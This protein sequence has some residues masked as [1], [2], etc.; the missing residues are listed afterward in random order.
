VGIREL[1]ATRA[2]DKAQLASLTAINV[3]ATEA[4]NALKAELEQLRATAQS[5]EL[6]QV[7]QLISRLTT[8]I[9]SGSLENIRAAELVMEN[10]HLMV[11]LH[12]AQKEVEE[13]LHGVADTP[14][15]AGDAQTPEDFDADEPELEPIEPIV[16]VE[17]VDAVTVDMRQEID[18]ENWYGAEADGRWAGPG[19][20]SSITMPPVVPGPYV[21]EIYLADAMA[22]DIVYGLRLEAFG[23]D[24][25]FEL[26]AAVTREAFPIACVATIEA[27]PEAAEGEWSLG[28][29]FPRTVSPAENGSSDTR[30]L[31]MRVMGVQL[32]RPDEL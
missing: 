14:P 26:S 15:G 27:P 11:A 7:S 19:L 6:D 28:F 32:K 9:E 5:A 31:A 21:A 18:G 4:Q 8:R 29:T 10:E 16:P 2:A 22:P 24:V 12:Q 17:P 1:I 3:E 13:L 20:Q 30:Q 23:V 25:P